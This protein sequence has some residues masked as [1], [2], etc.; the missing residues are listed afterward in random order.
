MCVGPSKHVG[1]GH[2]L[3]HQAETANEGSKPGAD[4]KEGWGL[5]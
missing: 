4:N 3:R 1:W 2:G 5:W